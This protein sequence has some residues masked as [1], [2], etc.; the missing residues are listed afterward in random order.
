MVVIKIVLIAVACSV[1]AVTVKQIKPE[2]LPFIQIA[3]VLVLLTVSM[4]SVH[5]IIEKLSVLTQSADGFVTESVFTLFKVLATAIATKLAC[6][7]CKDNGNSSIAVCT[8]LAGKIII[9]LMC[10]PLVKT[11]FELSLRFIK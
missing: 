2:F 8:E 6:E 1:F 3:S 5:V 9:I 7:I 10:F 4:S 11:I